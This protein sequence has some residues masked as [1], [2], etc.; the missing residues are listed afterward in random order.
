MRTSITFHMPTGTI[1]NCRTSSSG[2]QI[3]SSDDLLVVRILHRSCAD[4]LEIKDVI[5]FGC[6]G[7]HKARGEDGF[8]DIGI[9]TKDL[10]HAE[11]LE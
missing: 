9:G 6:R 2:Q 11:M 5:L 7:A 4:R 8:T 3:R 1:I 10:M